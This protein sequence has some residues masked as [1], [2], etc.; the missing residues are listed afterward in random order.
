MCLSTGHKNNTK[1]TAC[2]VGG[3]RGG[4]TERVRS[5]KRTETVHVERCVH[6]TLYLHLQIIT[7]MLIHIRISHLF[8]TSEYY[9]DNIAISESK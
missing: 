2:G 9:N 6:Y 4:L 8:K 5:N 7:S 1:H 3:G